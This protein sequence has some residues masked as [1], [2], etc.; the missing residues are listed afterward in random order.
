MIN[1]K[2]QSIIDTKSAI[3]NAIVNKGGTITTN[4]PFFNYAAQIDGLASGSTIDGYDESRLQSI[5]KIQEYG[6]VIQSQKI[7][8]GYVYVA[9]RTNRTVQKYHE[10]NLVFVGN[11]ASYGSDIETIAINNGFIYVGGGGSNNSVQKYHESNLAFVGNTVNY[12]GLIKS[13]AINNSKIFVGGY[14]NRVSSFTGT[15]QVFNE[16]TLSF[17]NNTA[18]YGDVIAVIKLSNGFIY[19]GGDTPSNQIQVFGEANLSRTINSGNIGGLVRSLAVNNGFVYVN[20]NNVNRLQKRHASNLSLQ[21]NT[22]NTYESILHADGI[23]INNGFIY[24]GGA[25]TGIKTNHITKFFESNLAEVS[26]QQYGFGMRTITFNNNALFVAG[27]RASEKRFEASPFTN[28]VDNQS[29]YLIP[30][31]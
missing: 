17:I 5:N 30:K 27:E 14:D 24:T 16:S 23:A 2:L 31:E 9:G 18:G 4:T 3:G 1:T 13:I 29:W 22:T 26:S 7:N 20:P 8:N 11:T 25:T 15:V 10:S 19:V 12:G 21:S 6:G 28:N